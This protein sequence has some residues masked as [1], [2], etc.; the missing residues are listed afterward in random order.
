MT[1]PEGR[2]RRLD[3]EI[4]ELVYTA[5]AQ[6]WRGGCAASGR[7]HIKLYPK[8]RSKA[9]VPVSGTPSEY[10]GLKNLRA[11]LRRAGLEGV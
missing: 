8:D 2:L 5:L 4:R 1:I 10:R 11:Q 3:P 9:P 6:G 7:G